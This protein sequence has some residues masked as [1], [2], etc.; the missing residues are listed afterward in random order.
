[1]HA[2][3]SNRGGSWPW[4]MPKPICTVRGSAPDPAGGAHD[5]PQTPWS[6]GE[7]I[8][9]P[10]PLPSRRLHRLDFIC[11]PLQK[12]LVAPVIE[13]L[14]ELSRVIHKFAVSSENGIWLC[15]VLK[16]ST[17]LLL[18]YTDELPGAV[19]PG[20][21]LTSSR[22]GLEAWRTLSVRVKASLELTKALQSAL[23]HVDRCTWNRV[24]IRSIG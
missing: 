17:D 14:I 3:I 13:W 23:E 16:Q 1:M 15:C 8:L 7:G 22:W 6:A 12:I 18:L 19:A 24:L 9:L 20:R 5:A 10:I 11:P 21:R 4:N 2:I